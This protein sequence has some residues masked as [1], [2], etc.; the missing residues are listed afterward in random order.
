MFSNVHGCSSAAVKQRRRSESTSVHPSHFRQLEPKTM[1]NQQL[2]H[3]KVHMSFI[4]WYIQLLSINSSNGPAT[5]PSS[6]IFLRYNCS[7]IRN[8]IMLPSHSQH[9]RQRKTL[10]EKHLQLA[11]HIAD[12]LT[13]LIHTLCLV[14]FDPPMFGMIRDCI[15]DVLA[16]LSLITVISSPN[17][18]RASSNTLRYFFGKD[19]ITWCNCLPCVLF[20][21][22]TCDEYRF[23]FLVR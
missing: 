17:P 22:S 19:W 1:P 12:E 6:L 13:T 15:A 5:V 10:Y 2:A 16:A 18:R 14:W 21:L 3:I 9:A 11:T 4:P 23:R 7:P 20:P 8:W